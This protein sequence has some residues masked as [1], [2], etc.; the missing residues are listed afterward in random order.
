VRAVALQVVIV[1]SQPTR[2]VAVASMLI[3]GGGH[4]E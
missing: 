4:S 2:A 3:N 1:I